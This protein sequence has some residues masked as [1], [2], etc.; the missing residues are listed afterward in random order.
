MKWSLFAVT[1]QND[2]HSAN[3]AIIEDGVTYPT[4]TLG[5]DGDGNPVVASEYVVSIQ[6][7]AYVDGSGMG[8]VQTNAVAVAKKMYSALDD[9]F[10]FLLIWSVL[11]HDGGT[12]SYVSVRNSVQGI[13]IGGFADVFDNT[14]D[15]QIPLSGEDNGVLTGYIQLN[16]GAG[17]TVMAALHH[18]VAHRWG[19]Y[20]GSGLGVPI[21]SHLNG[22]VEGT[23]YYIGDMAAS[24]GGGI[25]TEDQ[26]ASTITIVATTSV[27]YSQLEL[28]LMGM[29]PK[30]D[31][32]DYD[33]Y[34]YRISDKHLVEKVTVGPDELVAAYGERVPN[35]NNSKKKFNSVFMVTS[36]PGEELTQAEFA[37]YSIA[38]E[39]YGSTSA[40]SGF[41]NGP[42]A[43]TPGSFH[44][45]TGG[46]ATMSSKVL[47]FNPNTGGAFAGSANT[48]SSITWTWDSV[49]GAT[50]YKVF[51]TSDSTEIADIST[52][53]WNEL[54][55]S[56]NTSYGRQVQAYNTV[57]TSD[58]TQSATVYT[59]AAA[60]TSFALV[61]VFLASVTVSWAHNNN[62]ASTTTYR[63]SRWEAGSST[64]SVVIDG[65]STTLT[66]LSSNTTY[67]FGIAALNGS[68]LATTSY[69]ILSTVT[70]DSTQI[71]SNGTGGGDWSDAATWTGAT[72]PTDSRSVI[73]AAGDTVVVDISGADAGTTTING[74]L[75]FSRVV[76]SSLTITG[77]D[78]TVMRG[79]TL[80][81]GTEA[82]PIPDGINARLILAGGT[83]EIFYKLQVQDGGNFTV[84]GATKTPHALIAH[85]ILI[86]DTSFMIAASEAVGWALGDEITIGPAPTFLVYGPAYA[87]RAIITGIAGVDP[88]TITYSLADTNYAD[89]IES[90]S[91]PVIVGNLT[92]NVRI[93]A[94]DE[95]GY[96]PSIENLAQN[97][98][99]FSIVHGVVSDVGDDAD[100]VCGITFNGASVKGLISSST[101]RDC[102]D[103]A[104][105]FKSG[106]SNITLNYNNI[107][108]NTRKGLS[109][110]GAGHTITYNNI[111]ANGGSGIWISGSNHTVSFNYS[112][113]N[114]DG[115]IAAS[116][117]VGSVVES[118]YVY[119]NEATSASAPAGIELSGTTL[120]NAF[121]SNSIFR[122][123]VGG[124]QSNGVALSKNTIALNK[125][126]GNG[127]RGVNISYSDENKIVSNIVES[128]AGHGFLVYSFNEALAATDN[129]LL[130]NYS[131]SNT[132]YGIYLTGPGN[133]FIDGVL[134]YDEQ[135]NSAPNTLAETG[136]APEGGAILKNTRVNPSAG[137]VTSACIADYFLISYN[138]DYDTGTV[139][140]W[141]DYSL[142]GSTLTLDYNTDLYASTATVPDITKGTSISAIS[143]NSTN[144]ANALSQLVTVK[145][146]SSDNLWHVTGSSS[147]AM[148]TLA[149]GGGTADFPGA[150]AQFNLTLTA[151][152]DQD[153]DRADFI[154]LAASNDANIQKKLLFGPSV[155]S[156]NQGRSKITIDTDAGIVL[157]GDPQEYTLVDMFSSGSTYYTF[158]DSGAFTAEFSSFTNMDPSGI[159][160]SG[161]AGVS[162]STCIFDYLGF[163]SGTNTFI[164]ARDLT[165]NTTLY[166]VGFF[167]NRS[168]SGFDSVYNVR[169]EGDDSNLDWT[170]AL[171]SGTL[172]G[173]SF[174]SD[175]N[176]KVDWM[177]LPE[178][179]SSFSGSVSGVSSITWTWDNVDAEDGFRIVSSTDGNV[180]GDLDADTLSWTE[181]NLSTNTQYSRRVVAFN[182]LGMSTSTSDTL[183]TLA[184]PPTG[185]ALVDVFLTSVTVEW[186]HN[187]NP[188]STTTYRVNRWE[189]GTSTTSIIVDGTST[190]LTGLSVNTTYYF[191]IAALNGN[192]LATTSYATL[193]SVTLPSALSA[194][195]SSDL[196]ITSMSWTWGS[197]SGAHY[198]KVYR[199]SDTTLLNGNV[200]SNSFDET[201]LS[202][203]TAYGLRVSA[204]NATGESEL[205]S[206]ATYYTLA[207][208]P[209][210]FA[211]VDVFLTS[212][213]V[214]WGA[215]S[216]P[217]GTTY[218]ASIWEQG[219]STTTLSVTSTTIDFANLDSGD[220]YY[221]TVS[222]VN[223]SS[224][225]SPSGI[226][227]STRTYSL[228]SAPSGLSGTAHSASSMVWT[229]DVLANIDY[230][231]VYRASDSTLLDANVA[232]ESFTEYSLSTNTAYGLIVSGVSGP[233]EGTLSDQVTYYTLASPPTGFALVD[234]FLT[235]VTVSWG[236]NTNPNGTI[237]N[238]KIWEI[239]GSTTTL[240]VTSTTIVFADLDSG[241]TYYMTVEA[242]N[243][244]SLVT[245]SDITLSTVTFIVPAQISEPSGI[246]LGVSSISWT[247]NSVAGADYYMVYSASS[248]SVI[249]GNAAS[250][251]YIQTD[252]ST[253][254]AYGIQVS[255]VN[256]VYEGSL[257]DATTKYTLAAPPTGFAVV[258]VFITSMTVSWAHNTNPPS[259]TTY[260]VDRWEITG[261]T[262]SI[263]VDDISTALA[264]LTADTTYYLTIH[265]LNAD[266]V[267]TGSGIELS[268]V[269][270][271]IAVSTSVIDSSVPNVVV[272]N[273]PSGEVRIDVPA[274]SFAGTA[275]ITVQVPSS[276][277]TAPSAAASL[278]VTGVGI[279]ISSD[280]TLDSTKEVT[281]A[282]S[283]KDSEVLGMD[284]NKLIIARYDVGRDIWIPLP[285]TP[286]P[287]NNKVSGRTNHFSIFQIMQANPGGSVSDVKTYPNP[288]RPAKGHTLMTFS[289]LPAT[290]KLK[291]YTF[292]GE[293]VQE[294]TSNASGIARWDAKNSYGKK[295]ASGVYFVFAEGA[296]GKK[297]FK[298]A[299]QR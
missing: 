129:I 97:T 269:T 191:G 172:W 252:L 49:A 165:S 219:G 236:A 243:G 264:G 169:A 29:I 86:V 109:I 275:Q 212:A 163:A 135:G 34:K 187:N 78:I 14:A 161:N 152:S 214:T 77:G 103:S 43:D 201:S 238:A 176:S 288:F 36:P 170:F 139:R 143:V 50:G 111:C 151:A 285:S 254:T 4:V 101:V 193:S 12:N 11:K 240:S 39:H 225:E 244:N 194:P 232:S 60:P 114:V 266:S 67:Y 70:L 209:T 280:K 216:N 166:S 136:C 247:W 148:G 153:G 27:M 71:T 298:I 23:T 286:D 281:I 85:D 178:A 205:S 90:S 185:F 54:N 21:N 47:A 6:D 25:V 18:E 258:D 175:I 200:T 125:I 292:S 58:L 227:L 84:R 282:I 154:L 98:T 100:N 26:Q 231:K 147:G 24:L 133:I 92:R 272:F 206:I 99:S 73:I 122:N 174:D 283:Y 95:F 246:A 234:V 296:G 239:T 9:T 13:G 106:P 94:V 69:A 224:A 63:V 173:E 230:Y 48:T 299:I 295:V 186:A 157:A 102:T 179:A 20:M 46:R 142:S 83:S 138:Q 87:N 164:T 150:S 196:G 273:A 215:N 104:V 168:S 183:Y 79:G 265:A 220:T 144:D 82:L 289:N 181:T 190:T 130:S 5:T 192:S 51:T 64:T 213:T 126:F 260:R 256:D 17:N 257:S 210:G 226:E 217:N 72:V 253:N 33:F 167:M 75:A 203:N 132:S 10:D 208:P 229:W 268:T 291:I 182:D 293:L 221:M 197:L 31:M 259:T 177:A 262:T 56:T 62:P 141:G 218:Y 38:A 81:M 30:E 123:K 80:D 108:S 180:S 270:Q 159:Q 267:L 41:I 57:G 294:L 110:N 223:G 241:D 207:A 156:F 261:S 74:T 249:D 242:Q 89:S 134:G 68:S 160:L 277:P 171:S 204:V 112:H 52:N 237:Y 137:I 19:M 195:T 149:A 145:Y 245:A 65:T 184:A 189:A 233:Y 121:V 211:L 117:L 202:T 107:Y 1:I 22:L 158:V 235:S 28:Y 128:N 279:D 120:R 42:N 251:S 162:I 284:E 35:V 263:V 115:G 93:G 113:S 222:A 290:A 188:A 45:A 66:G 276:L 199:G 271:Y 155:T 37:L 61:D 3:M 140:I 127:L 287:A 131:F 88:L 40:G 105:C 124:F 8:S 7:D 119:C 44:W 53:T 91:T 2:Q 96:L 250:G 32:P 146:N 59:L 255:G 15:H 228:P 118:N 297:T 116:G 248:A 274:N 278:S 198:Y 76:N 16:G 55:L